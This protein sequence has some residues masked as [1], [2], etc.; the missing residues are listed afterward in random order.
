MI[1]EPVCSSKKLNQ[2]YSLHSNVSF[3]N[4]LR[5]G[6]IIEKVILTNQHLPPLR[7][8]FSLSSTHDISVLRQLAKYVYNSLKTKE[9]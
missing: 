3:N 6:S 1:N 2:N 9:V 7:C 5:A 4:D 8:F